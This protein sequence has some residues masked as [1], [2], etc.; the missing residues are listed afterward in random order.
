MERFRDFVLE[1]E[2]AQTTP[3]I[4]NLLRKKELL[5]EGNPD[6]ERIRTALLVMGGGMR[7]VYGAGV[8]TGLEKAGFHDV[9]D[10]T[11]GVSAGAADIAYFLAGQ[12]EYGTPIYYEQLAN[13]TFI[14]FARLNKIMDIDYVDHICRFVKPLD[15]ERIRQSRSAFYIGVTNARTGKGEMI[16]AKT[17]GVDIV[18][19]MRASAA[20]PIVYNKSVSVNGVEYCDGQIGHGIPLDFVLDSACTDVL[21]VLNSPISL[22]NEK[23]AKLE[24]L[25]SGVLLRKFTPE[26]RTA[27][28]MRN[29]LYNRSLKA[30]NANNTVNIGII[31]PAAISVS[32]FSRDSKTM[33]MVAREAEAQVQSLF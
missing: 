28:V 32:F 7:G 25:L 8:V 14:N 27:T 26:F 13:K 33:Q 29:Q 4:K 22:M 16:D 10:L 17:E 24:R 30:L 2:K 19:L 23:N 31:A 3:L 18:D 1:Q 21:L 15:Q 6:H 5:A 11:A 12:A 9:F 20:V